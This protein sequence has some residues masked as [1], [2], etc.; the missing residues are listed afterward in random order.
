MPRATELQMSAHTGQSEKL[1]FLGCI[2]H[3]TTCGCKTCVDAWLVT[4][5]ETA[6]LIRRSNPE[7]FAMGRVLPLKFGPG[8]AALDSNTPQDHWAYQA[9]AEIRGNGVAP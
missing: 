3:R 1:A 6:E 8:W 7:R 5:S 2:G 4:E 9:L